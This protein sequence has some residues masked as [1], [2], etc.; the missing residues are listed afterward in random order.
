MT[1]DGRIQYLDELLPDD[2][3]GTRATTVDDSSLSGRSNNPGGAP[4]KVQL[5]D[6]RKRVEEILGQPEAM[7]DLGSKVVY[8]YRSF[9]V[10]FVDGRVSDVQ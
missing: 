9:K 4:K 3:P 1:E 2:S 6:S 8:V 7:A 10:T 5:G